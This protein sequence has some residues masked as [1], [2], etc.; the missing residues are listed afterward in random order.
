MYLPTIFLM[1]I[2]KRNGGGKKYRNKTKCTSKPMEKR[3]EKRTHIYP[4]LIETQ[5]S[6]QNER[7]IDV[8]LSISTAHWLGRKK[9]IFATNES[10]QYDTVGRVSRAGQAISLGYVSQFSHI[11][12]YRMNQIQY[13]SIQLSWDCACAWCRF[14][15][16]TAFQIRIITISFLKSL[17][18]VRT[19][20]TWAVR[21]W[22]CNYWAI[23]GLDQYCLYK[24]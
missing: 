1:K 8:F 15:N 20:E 23:F 14:A 18:N 21:E 11:Y 9:K 4:K 13:N 12:A 24:F 2:A 16:W 10:N 17:Q 19:R 7:K 6:K 5:K 3:N 22:A